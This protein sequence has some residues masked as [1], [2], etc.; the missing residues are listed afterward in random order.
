MAL[1]HSSVP[2]SHGSVR[3]RQLNGIQPSLIWCHCKAPPTQNLHTFPCFW[4]NTVKSSRVINCVHFLSS[5][6][7]GVAPTCLTTRCLGKVSRGWRNAEHWL[8]CRDQ[9]ILTNI[10][11]IS[12]K[13]RAL[14]ASAPQTRHRPHKSLLVI[15][16]AFLAVVRITVDTMWLWPWDE[17]PPL[18]R[19]NSNSLSILQGLSSLVSTR[20]DSGLLS[21]RLL[22]FRR[23]LNTFILYRRVRFY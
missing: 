9:W 2:V 21:P 17:F 3:L 10:L 22:T 5:S 12:S 15:E 16:T 4:S 6:S 20:G 13:V 14:Q 8:I 19:V 11:T 18:K 7:P 23:L 1:F